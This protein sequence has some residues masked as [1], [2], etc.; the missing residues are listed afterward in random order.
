MASSNPIK[1]SLED[2]WDEGLRDNQLSGYSIGLGSL[3]QSVV[4]TFM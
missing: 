4:Y 2:I 1:D 3:P